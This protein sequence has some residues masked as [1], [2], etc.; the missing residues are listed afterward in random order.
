MHGQL[1]KNAKVEVAFVTPEPFS[2]PGVHSPDTKMLRVSG[3]V[4]FVSDLAIRKRILDDRPFLKERYGIEKPEDPLL[5]VMRVH[6][7][8]AYFWTGK[9]S[10]KESE[11]PRIRF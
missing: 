8:E 11:L 10:M 4:E 7:G 5:T 6:S 3:Q 9:D 2:A 1:E